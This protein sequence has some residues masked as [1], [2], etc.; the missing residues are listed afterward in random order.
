MN[1]GE[2]THTYVRDGLFLLTNLDRKT[3]VDDWWTSSSK[4]SFA[5]SQDIWEMD[6]NECVF[7]KKQELNSGQLAWTS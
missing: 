1:L 7:Q 3:S 5:K 4:G 6:V 2:K